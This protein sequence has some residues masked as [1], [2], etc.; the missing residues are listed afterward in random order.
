MVHMTT[1]FDHCQ[2]LYKINIKITN[3]IQHQTCIPAPNGKK[4][5][6]ICLL[7]SLI[8][9]IDMAIYSKRYVSFCH[10][11]GTSWKR[12]KILILGWPKELQQQISFYNNTTIQQ[13]ILQLFK[14]D[15]N[16]ERF[17]TQMVQKKELKLT[18]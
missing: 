11:F 3:N 2:I 4:P 12:Y 9:Q 10:N 5:Y 8:M 17:L 7:S 15:S 16:I 6:S 14:K 18:I 13:T 1:I